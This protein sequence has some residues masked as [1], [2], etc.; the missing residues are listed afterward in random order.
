[1]SNA[2]LV[3]DKVQ[4]MLVDEMNLNVRLISNG[5]QVPF[6]STAVNIVV[7]EQGEGESARVLLKMWAPV[8]REVRE[9]PELFKWIA[10]EG[11]AFFFGHACWNP[12]EA[13]PGTGMLSFDHT[14]LGDYLDLPELFTALGALATTAD[15]LDDSLRPRFGGQRFVDPDQ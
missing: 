10:N 8:L 15:E 3:R 11:T 6:E 1:M 4:R 7:I 14:L 13:N 2:A 5:F 12:D 9:T